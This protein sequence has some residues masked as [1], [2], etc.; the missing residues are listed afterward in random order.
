MC[1]L[2]LAK[3]NPSGKAIALSKKLANGAIKAATKPRT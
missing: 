2:K 3:P 1:G